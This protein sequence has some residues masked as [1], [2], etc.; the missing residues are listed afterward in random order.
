[1]NDIDS[2]AT[3][4]LPPK[5]L[6]DV[7]KTI[8]T[9][10]ICILYQNRVLMIKRSE[11][12]KAFPGW[13]T[14]PGG[15]IDEGEDPLTAAI[16]E[17]KEETGILLTPQELQL[18]FTAIHHHIDR[19]EQYIVFGFVARLTE[20]PSELIENDEGTLH[21]IQVKDLSTQSK[22]FPPV[23]YYFDHLL[24]GQG[25]KYNNSIWENTRLVK[26]LSELIDNNS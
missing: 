18:K 8:F 5:R 22:I 1:M 13:I 23:Q 20:K 17:A 15:H 9:V 25:I 6:H 14:L 7:A 24:Y 12:K 21:W 4:D 10:D 11:T 26:V 3:L 16:R 19:N 2:N